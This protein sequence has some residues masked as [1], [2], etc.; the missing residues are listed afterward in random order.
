M[1]TEGEM[2]EELLFEGMIELN[3]QKQQTAIQQENCDNPAIVIESN[4]STIEPNGCEKLTCVIDNKIAVR[5]PDLFVPNLLVPL[6]RNVSEINSK[7]SN[8]DSF[9]LKVTED[10]IFEGY[11]PLPS[12]FELLFNNLDERI[13]N[14]TGALNTTEEN[15]KK[16]KH[17]LKRKLNDYEGKKQYKTIKLDTIKGKNN[18]NNPMGNN[19]TLGKNTEGKSESGKISASANNKSLVDGNNSKEICDKS[20]SNELERESKAN[21]TPKILVPR[22]PKSGDEWYDLSGGWKKRCMQRKSGSSTGT[23]DVYLY[24]PGDVKRLRSS[25]ELMRFVKDHP[26]MSI[27]PLEVNMDLPFKVSP[28][29]KPSLATQKLITAIKE[30][31]ERGS[32]S[33]KLFGATAA[34]KISAAEPLSLHL[35]KTKKQENI[36][37]K[38]YHS[39]S[40]ANSSHPEPIMERP[41]LPNHDNNPYKKTYLS[42]SYMKRN[43]FAPVVFKKPKPIDQQRPD[44]RPKI[45][46]SKR[47]TMGKLFILERLFASSICMPTPQKVTEWAAKLDLNRIEVMQWFRVKWRSKLLYEAEIEEIRDQ[48][49]AIDP[50]NN[51]SPDTLNACRQKLK[52]DLK[53]AYDMVLDPTSEIDLI[54]EGDFVIDFETEEDDDKSRSGDEDNYAFD[55]SSGDENIE[56]E[57]H[58]IKSTEE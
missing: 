40:Y 50:D 52:F 58:E 45:F 51:I 44:T 35:C 9:Y 34:E 42:Q 41:S 32:I 4:M 5:K 38:A 56:I 17:A 21:S 30:I 3:M 15:S 53:K 16:T 25:T 49:D 28:D 20:Q 8:I 27:D 43:R 47:P 13:N 7:P 33:Q 12:D 6:L 24:P 2:K 18:A 19:D 57:Y 31:K 1:E 55:E 36:Y 10:E 29:G 48:L 37:A 22:V 46:H 14:E 54:T 39:E 26:E 23:W 11:F